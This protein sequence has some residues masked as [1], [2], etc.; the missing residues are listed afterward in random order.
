MKKYVI[1]VDKNTLY[2]SSDDF[3]KV[4]DKCEELRQKNPLFWRGE[5]KGKSYVELDHEYQGKIG[6]RAISDSVVVELPRGKGIKDLKKLA[7]EAI[8][9]MIICLNDNYNTLYDRKKGLTKEKAIETI[10]EMREYKSNLIYK[11]SVVKIKD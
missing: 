10:R 11:F 9:D 3:K 2:Y 5:A 7:D 8:V 6:N 1:V 4:L